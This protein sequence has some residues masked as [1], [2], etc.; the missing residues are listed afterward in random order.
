MQLG[1]WFN[2]VKHLALR[3]TRSGWIHTRPQLSW[4]VKWTTLRPVVIK[5]NQSLS[6]RRDFY[7]DTIGKNYRHDLRLVNYNRHVPLLN[8]KELVNRAFCG[9]ILAHWNKITNFQRISTLKIVEDVLKWNNGKFDQDQRQIYD[10]QTDQFEQEGSYVQFNIP[11]II[12]QDADFALTLSEHN[13]WLNEADLN[14]WQVRICDISAIYQDISKIF[15]T[16]GYL[17]ISKSQNK[18]K[19]HFPNRTA[20][21]TERLLIDLDIIHGT[22]FANVY[23][24][25]RTP[26][27]ILSSS[28]DDASM[29]SFIDLNNFSPVLSETL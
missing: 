9:R 4:G 29:E 5:G 26:T 27:E 21:E 3:V 2:S 8:V 11:D 1:N 14:Q 23:P 12:D 10:K 16:Y 18:L 22:V 17:P 20:S 28:E 24:G 15:H 7:S 13:R 19:I 6:H 25:E